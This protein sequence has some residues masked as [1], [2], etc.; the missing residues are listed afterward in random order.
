MTELRKTFAEIETVPITAPVTTTIQPPRQRSQTRVHPSQ[1]T[2]PSLKGWGDP[3]EGLIVHSNQ[4]K[5]LP[6]FFKQFIKIPFQVS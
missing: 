6:D 1:P 2:L 5:V 4:V 3:K